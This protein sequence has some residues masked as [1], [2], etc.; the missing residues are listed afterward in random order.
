MILTIL[1]TFA[2]AP[3]VSAQLLGK[4]ARLLG[5]SLDFLQLCEVVGFRLFAGGLE[6]LADAFHTRF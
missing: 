2:L 6:I 4:S 3:I 1:P 5:G